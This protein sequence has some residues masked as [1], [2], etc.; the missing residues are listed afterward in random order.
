MWLPLN[1]QTGASGGEGM[2][3]E[4]E[5]REEKKQGRRFD[6]FLLSENVKT[7]MARSAL[8]GNTMHDLCRLCCDCMCLPV[9]MII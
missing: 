9:E 8:I 7:T 5:N 1:G 4:E 2:T 6:V 3:K